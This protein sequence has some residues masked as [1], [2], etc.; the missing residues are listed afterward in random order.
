[1]IKRFNITLFVLCA[2]LLLFATEQKSYAQLTQVEQGT[3]WQK[4]L[5]IRGI[6]NRFDPFNESKLYQVTTSDDQQIS[7]EENY[8]QFE[9]LASDFWIVLRDS[10]QNAIQN[11]EVDV[12][13]VRNMTPN[14][15]DE[16]IGVFGKGTKVTYSDLLDT[17]SVNL[18]NMDTEGRFMYDISNTGQPLPQDRVVSNMARQGNKL[19]DNF[20]ALS[21]FEVEVTLRVDETGFSMKPES[22]LMGTTH[23]T[24]VELNMDNLMEGFL[25]GIE[26]NK[27]G[28]IIDLQDEKT[29]QYL[30]ENGIQFSGEQ[31]LVPFY[32]LISL[33]HYEYKVYAESNNVVAV[34]LNKFPDKYPNLEDLEQTL[35]NRY[36]DLT[37]Q[38]LY[39]E[40]P[41]WWKEGEKGAFTNGMFDVDILPENQQNQQEQQQMNRPQN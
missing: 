25:S 39:G 15:G 13:T 14:L 22:I 10:L 3:N 11:N 9:M 1:M 5:R 34:A 38:H 6:I 2:G 4:T 30:V 16:S 19:V 29:L 24:R 32:D 17:L 37:Y 41:R 23:W 18:Q 40:P 31:N 26:L 33:F 7:S 20:S 36:N 12:Y 27:V 8:V 35:L 28:F 21:M